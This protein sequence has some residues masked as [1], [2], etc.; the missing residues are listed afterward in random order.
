MYARGCLVSLLNCLCG[1]SSQCTL[2][3]LSHSCLHSSGVNGA[4]SVCNPD[5]YMAGGHSGHHKSPLERLGFYG[6]TSADLGSPHS[7]ACRTRASSCSRLR[8]QQKA[9]G[10]YER[11]LE[12]F[13]ADPWI[14]PETRTH[15]SYLGALWV[16]CEPT[17]FPGSRHSDSPLSIY[18]R[19]PT[20]HCK[21]ARPPLRF[22]P[23]NSCPLLCPSWGSYLNSTFVSVSDWEPRSWADSGCG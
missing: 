17:V 14:G 13:C 18:K 8:R 16:K 5:E 9:P 6:S 1:M 7:P 23:I 22:R 4:M 19:L 11:L 2:L 21:T 12:V 10:W 15:G 3:W 20:P